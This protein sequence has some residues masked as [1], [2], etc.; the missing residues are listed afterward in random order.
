ML[1]LDLNQRDAEIAFLRGELETATANLAQANRDKEELISEEMGQKHSDTMLK[2][3]K[4]ERDNLT[5]KLSHAQER[6]TDLEAL[7]KERVILLA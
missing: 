1:E 3:V 2:V 7:K 5:K 6:L 4:Q